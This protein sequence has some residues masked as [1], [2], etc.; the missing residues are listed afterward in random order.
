MIDAMTTVSSLQDNIN[1]IKPEIILYSGH[2]ISFPFELPHLLLHNENNLITGSLYVITDFIDVLNSNTNL[3]L[4]ILLTCYS[5]KIK[6]YLNNNEKNLNCC[7]ITIEELAHDSAMLSFLK[8]CSSEI[9]NIYSQ[10]EDIGNKIEQI[11]IAGIEQFKLDKY[12]IG[13]PNPEN[14]GYGK[15]SDLKIEDRVLIQKDDPNFP[16]EEGTIKSVV[17]NNEKNYYNVI[18]Q[19]GSIEKV[20]FNNIALAL[21]GTPQ[22]IKYQEGTWTNINID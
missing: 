2:I 16:D 5:Y 14:Y 17:T 4:V 6:E 7:F 13:N 20:E 3:K 8:G 9:S 12:N 19:N 1:T 22:L 15:N 10:N 21:H 18:K 11:F